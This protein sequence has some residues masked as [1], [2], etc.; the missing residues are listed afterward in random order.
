MTE[1]LAAARD[2]LWEFFAGFALAAINYWLGIR[3]GRRRE[4]KDARNRKA[5]P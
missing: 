2:G 1:F 4:R 5:P 3:E